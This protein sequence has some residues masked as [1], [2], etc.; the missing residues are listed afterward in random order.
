MSNR[1]STSLLIRKMQIQT[2][3]RYHF[4]PT[5]IAIQNTDTHTHTENKCCGGYGKIV[6]LIHC[7]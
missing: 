7:G 4:T 1:H 6:S 3:V 2:T 5:G